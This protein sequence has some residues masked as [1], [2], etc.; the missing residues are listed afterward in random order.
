MPFGSG[1]TDKTADLAID[2]ADTKQ[3]ISG[4]LSKI[5]IER[6]KIITYIE[7]ISDSTT[8]QILFYKCVSNYNWFQVAREMGPGYS[9]DGVKQT[10]YR[11]FKK[12]D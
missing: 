7:T 2:I 11:H 9:A 1:T 10:Y 4:L 5:Q 3:V 6:K 8:R 12:W